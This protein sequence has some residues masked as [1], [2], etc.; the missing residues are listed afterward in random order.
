[1]VDQWKIYGNDS[2]ITALSCGAGSYANWIISNCRLIGGGVTTS[3]ALLSGADT[4]NAQIL[5]NHFLNYE[6]I[7]VLDETA[8]LICRGNYFGT[9][10]TAA[11]VSVATGPGA[12]VIGNY[13]SGTYSIAGGYTSAATDEWLGNFTEAGVTAAKP[14]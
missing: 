3:D 10:A 8:G 5:F 13:F 7:A 1:M 4:V 6:S 12:A 9:F 11:L 2:E 14:A